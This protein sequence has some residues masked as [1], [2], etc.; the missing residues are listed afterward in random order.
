M[1]SNYEFL[2]CT[3][4][5]GIIRSI[6]SSHGGSFCKFVFSCH[7]IISV[8][9]SQQCYLMSFH[10]V[11]SQMFGHIHLAQTLSMCQILICCPDFPLA[12]IMLLGAFC[13]RNFSINCQIYSS[14]LD[15]TGRFKCSMICS[16][17]R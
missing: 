12:N 4:F 2:W 6:C 9:V 17:Q 14:T 3:Q 16:K 15:C 1:R 13:S 8:C 7:V 10:Q 5:K 11:W